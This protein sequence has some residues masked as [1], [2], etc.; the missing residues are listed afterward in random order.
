MRTQE[1][2]VAKM[3]TKSDSFFGFDKEVYVLGLDFEHAKPFLEEGTTAEQCPTRTEAEVTKEAA[4]YAEFAWGKAEDHRGLSAGRSV[5]KLTA[6]AW[7]LGRDDVVAA[8]EAAG[9]AQYGCPKLKAFCDGMG[10]PVPD[11]EE[12]MRMMRGESCSDYCE[13][14]CG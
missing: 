1:E 8:M 6:F 3:S 11:S 14:G 5:E 12:L 9:Y 4:G 13:S 2:I 7:L 10:F